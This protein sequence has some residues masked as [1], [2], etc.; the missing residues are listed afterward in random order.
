MKIVCEELLDVFRQ[1]TSCGWCKRGTSGADPHHIFSRGAGRLDIRVN[2]IP[3]CRLCHNEDDM[4]KVKYSVRHYAHYRCYLRVHGEAGLR[5]LPAWKVGQF[6]Y[7]LL[8]EYNLL[9]AA[10]RITGAKR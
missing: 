4:K 8:K 2:L 7:L 6:P 10:Y 3:L 1:A 5:S 9:D